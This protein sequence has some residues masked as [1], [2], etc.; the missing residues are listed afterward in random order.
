VV[1]SQIDP[2]HVAVVTKTGSLGYSLIEID[3][4]KCWPDSVY[5]SG[6]ILR[7]SLCWNPSRQ[8]RVPPFHRDLETAFC[9][10]KMHQYAPLKVNAKLSLCLTKYHAMLNEAWRHEDVLREWRYS[11]IPRLLYSQGKRPWYPLYRKLSEPRIGLDAVAKTSV[12][13]PYRKSNPS[14]PTCKPYHYSD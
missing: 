12:P 8:T 2:L 11:C 3:R 1:G 4:S 10:A 7:S 14:H 6:L 9:C 5:R 13:Y